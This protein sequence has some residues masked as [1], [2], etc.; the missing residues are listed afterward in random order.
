MLI[1]IPQFH[2]PTV[3][4]DELSL[5]GVHRSPENITHDRDLVIFRPHN[6]S[7]LHLISVAIDLS[8]LRRQYLADSPQLESIT[9]CLC[10]TGHIG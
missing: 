5:S 4:V 1:K 2:K 9:R 10:A 7:R 6:P 3:R 8:L